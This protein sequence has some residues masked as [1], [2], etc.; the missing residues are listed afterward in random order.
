MVRIFQRLICPVLHDY[1]IHIRLKNI[2]EK[3]YRK[4]LHHSNSNVIIEFDSLRAPVWFDSK[5][6]PDQPIAATLFSFQYR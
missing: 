1:T 4:R 2:N 6:F 3:L 5:Q